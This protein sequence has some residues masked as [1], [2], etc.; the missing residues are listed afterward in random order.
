[1]IYLDNSAT[2]KPDP[3]VVE[4]MMP[5]LH[6]GFGNPSS[7][8][9]IGRSAR[10]A[11]EEARAKVAA[12]IGA[13][14]SEIVFTSSG[15]EANNHAMKGTVFH[16]ASKGNRFQDQEISI[17]KTEHHAL[18]EP[19]E[20]LAKLG[21]KVNEIAVDTF[22]IVNTSELSTSLNHE[23]SFISAILV[24]NE[25]GAINPVRDI[26][27]LVREKAPNALIHT[28]A[29]QALGKIP[30]DV[31]ELGVDMLSLSAH[32]I[33]GPK[34]IG[35]LFIRRGIMIEPLLHGG[36][37]ERN[38]RGSTENV[39]YAAG[40]AKAAE[41]FVQEKEERAKNI[42]LL[43]K[44]LVE[45]L[46]AIPEIVFNSPLDGRGADAI[47]NISFIPEVVSKMDTDALFIRFD[48]DGI[49]I[50]NGAACTSGSMQPSHVLL[51]MGKSKEV[52]SRSVRVSLSKDTTEEDLDA[53]LATLR[54]IIP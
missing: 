32:K 48:M 1:M 35:A 24:N 33:N 40:F 52:A 54:K 17:T 21:V 43:R 39:A 15:T 51:A 30:V 49:A 27:P 44:Y 26:A 5:F 34:G 23:T 50:S 8:Y 28:D 42:S 16:L 3:R 4:A 22:G 46:K 20:F 6:D 41:L 45:Q 47:L 31:K 2:T 14:E 11:L 25:T 29:V 12:A 19:A 37:Q 53:F 18:L 10:I 9:E 7:I 36:A 13:E 38:R